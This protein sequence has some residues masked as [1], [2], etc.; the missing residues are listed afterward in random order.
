LTISQK[1]LSKNFG[2]Y[3]RG[4]ISLEE[5]ERLDEEILKKHEE[6]RRRKILDI[7]NKASSAENNK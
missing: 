6:D 4:E 3:R 5:Y 2:K 7:I 1:K